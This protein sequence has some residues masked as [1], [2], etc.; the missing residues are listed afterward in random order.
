MIKVLSKSTKV[1]GV[2]STF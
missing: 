1:Q 2:K